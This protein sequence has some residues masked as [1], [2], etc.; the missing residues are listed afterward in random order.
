[1]AE[2]ELGRGYLPFGYGSF[3]ETHILKRKVD[4]L[5]GLDQ[6]TQNMATIVG[7]DAAESLPGPGC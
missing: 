7:T 5:C 3:L 4:G 2:V 1:M 6:A